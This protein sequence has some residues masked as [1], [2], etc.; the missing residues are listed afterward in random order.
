MTIENLLEQFLS[1]S[2]FLV[3][4][5]R[6][7]SKKAAG[8]F[9][10]ISVEE[11][12]RRLDQHIAKLQKDIRERRYI[13]QPATITHIPKFNEE[14]EWREL[15]LPSVADKVVQAAL[16]QV[17]EP[18]AEKVFLDSS[19]A[20]RP[21]KGHYKALRRVE[22]SLNNRKKTWVIRRDI[23]NFFDTLLNSFLNWYREN[24]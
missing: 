1:T 11:F 19:Y 17:V 6:I 8:G 13:P 5:R 4:Y 21:G 10:G 23:D 14:N 15:G 12:G 9:D 7:A 2:N 16:L 18:L 24:P 20:Y 22:H 3:A